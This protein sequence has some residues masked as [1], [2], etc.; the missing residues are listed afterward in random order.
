MVEGW[1]GW[2]RGGRDSSQHLVPASFLS[3]LTSNSG[4]QWEGLPPRLWAK[5]QEAG[6]E[7]TKG[8]GGQAQG[9]ACAV[10]TGGKGR[11]EGERK[12]GCLQHCGGQ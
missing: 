8:G 2:G 4:A 7:G 11:G 1:L 12:S 9:G 6:E 3:A 5:G 10:A